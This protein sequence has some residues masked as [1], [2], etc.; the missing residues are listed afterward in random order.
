[1]ETEH[2]IRLTSTEIA[3]L[4][5]TYQNDT[6][7]KCVLS[8]FLSKVED[9]EIKGV[10]ELALS[11]SETHIGQLT[12]LFQSENFPIPLGFTGED[13]NV[14]ARRLFSDSF[15]LYY[16]KNMSKVGL[17]TYGMTYSMASRADTRTFFGDALRETMTLDKKVT[18][19][20]QNK[21]LY[22]R[23]PSIPTPDHIDFVK[24]QSFLFGGFFGF[25]EKR[26]LLS[27][28]I[29]QLFANIQTNSLGKALLMGFAQVVR[30]QEIRDYLLTGKEISN[31]HIKSFSE[32]CLD[33]DIPVPMT[34]DPDVMDSTEP[35]FS[36]K[37]ILFHVSLLV[38]AGT[39]NYA[40]SMAASPRKDVAANYVKL[41]AEIAAY[42]NH[43]AKL[44]I[45]NGWL[46]EP[47]QS[48]DR[49]KLVKA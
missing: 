7:A 44:M 18:Q 48:P 34:W 26:P 27:M 23:P 49:R 39:A 12:E 41:T 30:S 11:I 21:G 33:E 24:N 14:N 2:N 19:V 28:E 36:D 45:E 35:P 10:V 38:T 13:V 37:L 17:T 1:M 29:G 42:A 40:V 47:P 31:N 43:G 3:A 20:L 4:W 16:I 32:T 9:K 22:I 6:L 25:G 8:Y 5:T 15:F 46:E